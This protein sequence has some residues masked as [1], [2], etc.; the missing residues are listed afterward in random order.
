[1]PLMLNADLGEGMGSDEAVM[2]HVHQANIACGFHA[3]DQVSM[4]KTLQLAGQHGVMIGAH[5]G[6]RDMEGFGRRSIPHTPEEIVA[7]LHY[8]VA[9]LDGMARSRG[10]SL[11]Y[12]KP[13]GALY[14]D[15]MANARV[16]RAVMDAVASYHRPLRLMIQATPQAEQHH[17][18]AERA[19]LRLWL[20][21]FADRCYTDSGLLVPRS[22][23][24]AVYDRVR[25]LEQVAQLREEGAVTT[26]GGKRLIVPADTLCVHGDNPESIGI[27]RQIRELVG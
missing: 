22:Q 16:R 25:T 17:R 20:E 27:I 14:N 1:M 2:P 26:A 4:L 21:A 23:P 18:E 11:A 15:M 3:G 9:A 24:G 12:V 10:L 19:G 7:L 6:Y 13:H 8:Q 5:P